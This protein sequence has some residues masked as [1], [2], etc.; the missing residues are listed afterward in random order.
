MSRVIDGDTF[1]LVDGRQVRVLGIDSCEAGTY[2]GQEAKRMAESDL[3]NP[4]DA[5]ITMTREPGVDADQDRRL[6]RYVQ[7]DGYDFGEQMVR[8]DHT[9]VY[10]GRNDA[11]PDYI[12]RLYAAD[13][14]YAANPP[15]GRSC[16][17]PYPPA[18]TTGNTYTYES[19]DDG[20]VNMPDGA[21]T[22]GYCRGKWWC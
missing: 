10:Q 19:D 17:D 15:A 20:D 6:L 16:A 4:Y 12:A 22:G 21:L 13:T 18:P 7:L 11:A 9:G 3:T 14:E 1:E 8:Y 5:P 2:G